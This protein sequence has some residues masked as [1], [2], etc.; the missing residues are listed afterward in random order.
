MKPENQLIYQ[1]THPSLPK[2]LTEDE[3]CRY[4]GKSKAWAQRARFEGKGPRFIK[5]GRKPLYPVEF[6]REW[7][8]QNAADNTITQN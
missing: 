6:I 1:N 4:L 7:L 2:V 8:Y 3:L 5:A